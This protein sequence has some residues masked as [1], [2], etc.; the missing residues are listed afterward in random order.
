M[1]KREKSSQRMNSFHSLRVEKNRRFV[2]KAGGV[3]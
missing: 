3:K 2:F 1:F